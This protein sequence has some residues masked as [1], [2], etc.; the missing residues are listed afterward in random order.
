MPFHYRKRTEGACGSGRQPPSH[1]VTCPECVVR[2]DGAAASPS[3]QCKAFLSPALPVPVYTAWA[4][5]LIHSLPGFIENNSLQ[6][7]FSSHVFMM[8]CLRSD[9]WRVKLSFKSQLMLNSIHK[10]LTPAP[11]SHYSPYYSVTQRTA[12]GK[13]RVGHVQGLSQPHSGCW[14]SLSPTKPDQECC[15]CCCVPAFQY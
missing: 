7:E 14:Q 4:P 3:A 10:T 8:A 13:P 6:N 11:G 12:D 5:C 15:C 2:A 9:P 1:H